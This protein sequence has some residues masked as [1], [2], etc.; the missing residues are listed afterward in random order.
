MVV[1]LILTVVYVGEQMFLTNI[2]LMLDQA[3]A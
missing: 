3:S 2:I 1:K